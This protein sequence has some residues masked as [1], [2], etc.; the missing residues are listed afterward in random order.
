[1]GADETG[2]LA[3]LRNHRS[4]LIDPL[5]HRNGGRIVKTMGDGLLLEFPS[6]VAAVEFDIA[7]QTGLGERN[8]G[9]PGAKAIRFRIGVHIGDIII[10]GDDIF[11]NGVN[12]AA[13]VEPLAEP[14]GVSL[15]DDAYRQVRDRLDAAW[16]DGGE[17]EVKNIA[18]PLHVWHWRRNW[19]RATEQ[20]PAQA[21]SGEAEALELPE[22]PSIAVLPFD[23]MSGDPEQEYFAD[24]MTEDLITDLSKISGLFVVAR[25]SSFVFKGQPVDVREVARRLG[26]RYV[27]EGSVRKAGSRV[28]INVQLIDALSGGHLWAERVDG[29][30]ENVF[31][32]Q[33]DVGAKVVSAL[34]VRLQGDESERLQHVHTHN[35]GAY[36]LYVRA[37]ATPYPPLPERIGAAREMFEQVIE[38]DPDFA[39][40][41]AGVSWMLGFSAMWGHSDPGETVTRATALARK[42]VELDDSFGWSHVALGQ[43]LMLQGRHEQAVAAVDE[44][45]ARQ[46]NDAD[47]HAYRGLMLAMSGRPELGV[48]PLDLAIRLNPQ[49]I[50]GP[51]LNMRGIIKALGQDYDGAVQSLE[52]NISRH[53]PVGPP[54]LSWLA[55]AYWALG[56]EEEA[57]R[58][59]AQLA[60]RF[61]AF[62]LENWNFIK[63]LRSSEDSQR[64]HDLMLNAGLPE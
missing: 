61:P 38:L 12:I 6:V 63:L 53:G 13:R 59:L 52:E 11:G 46:P 29:T 3:T 58:V 26:V 2:T 1:M 39:G 24:G 44:A 37:K 64:I 10:E 4:E 27:L 54:A 30:I 56:R 22:K 62:R 8:K 28:R 55:T 31:E 45:V 19:A 21:S 25:N 16:D 7:M 47:A 34:S 33:D 18:R 14:D 42:A 35:L 41:Y 40:G 51:Y 23:N 48:E 49:F 43:A 32:L 15:S 17:H 9:V 5:I 20:E 36:E 57:G 60:A 50:N